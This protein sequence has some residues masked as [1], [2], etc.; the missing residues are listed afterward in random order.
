MRYVI[1]T[2][3]ISSALLL[4]SCS[5]D[6]GVSLAEASESQTTDSDHER[7]VPLLS[8][9]DVGDARAATESLGCENGVMSINELPPEPT[10][11][12]NKLINA[13]VA[14]YRTRTRENIIA[15]IDEKINNSGF[16]GNEIIGVDIPINHYFCWDAILR[17]PE[18]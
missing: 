17:I 15:N 6:S 5:E 14:H 2:I 8:T 18:N 7:A 3:T 13:N 1:M 9:A 12:R 16:S 11:L 10:T 4:M